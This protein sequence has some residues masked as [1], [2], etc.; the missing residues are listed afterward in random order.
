MNLDLSALDPVRD[1]PTVAQGLR[2]AAAICPPGQAALAARLL[3]GAAVIE[4][5]LTLYHAVDFAA[6]TNLETI[7][8]MQRAQSCERQ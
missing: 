5:L 1:G 8:A 2:D 6:R 4:G 3:T 7:T